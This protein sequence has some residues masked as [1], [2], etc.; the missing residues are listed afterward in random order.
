[1][2]V[3]VM[4]QSNLIMA[5]AGPNPLVTLVLVGLKARSLFSLHHQTSAFS[6]P[7][8][9]RFETWFHAKNCHGSDGLRQWLRWRQTLSERASIWILQGLRLSITE[10][11]YEARLC[12]AT[13]VV[14]HIIV[15]RQ[16]ED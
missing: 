8:V 9:S 14:V 5:L 2:L 1:M 11:T 3:M 6:E 13:E 12:C 16:G 7:I 15:L 10:V 4:T